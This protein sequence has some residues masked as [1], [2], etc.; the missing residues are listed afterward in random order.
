M[1]GSNEKP[2]K[3]APVKSTSSTAQK[4][5]QKQ[6]LSNKTLG[7]IIG[8]S[9]G[10]ILLIVGVILAVV[11]LGG[12]NRD[13]YRS[14]LNYM[15]D[16]SLK[17]EFDMSDVETADEAKEKTDDV[18]KE[19]NKYFDEL[20]SYKA[21]RD[22]DVKEAFDRYESDWKKTQPILAEVSEVMAVTIETQD[23]CSNRKY[24]SYIDKTGKQVGE[25][26]DKANGKC[27]EVL[28]KFKDS[29]NKSVADYA[30]GQYDYLKE[31]REYSVTM[32]NRYKS[33][34]Y[35]SPTPKYPSYPSA[36]GNPSLKLLNKL[37]DS[38]IDKSERKLQNVLR[39]K[40]RK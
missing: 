37:R 15:Q 31:M 34:N 14:A 22:K 10:F 2:V 32:A 35:S 24:I 29:K 13:D 16:F 19:V 1:D 38:K 18:T 11:F 33:R 8:G 6:G 12:P 3:K 26:F 36:S 28:E 30:K 4:P 27:M 23:V 17:D 39:D 7:W 21:M 5:A 9:V 20:R 40:A 25:E